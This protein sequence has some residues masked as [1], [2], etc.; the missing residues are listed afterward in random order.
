MTETVVVYVHPST[1]K[2]QLLSMF[3][4]DD[5]LKDIEQNKK[6]SEHVSFFQ[7][8]YT[9]L[10]TDSIAYYSGRTLADYS[11]SISVKNTTCTLR[12]A[13]GYFIYMLQAMGFIHMLLVDEKDLSSREICIT[14]QL[15]VL[16][17]ILSPVITEQ[18]TTAF[19]GLNL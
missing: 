7:A 16:R 5:I 11:L 13:I 12:Q 1:L 17:E 9:Q 3:F 15:E 18:S 6:I 10:L 4:Q 14:N 8:K 2:L 19:G